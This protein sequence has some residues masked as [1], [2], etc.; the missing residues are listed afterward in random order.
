MRVAA[1]LAHRGDLVMQR[2]P[3]GAQDMLAGD[4]DVDLGGALPTA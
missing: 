4:D 2:G 1:G 3:I